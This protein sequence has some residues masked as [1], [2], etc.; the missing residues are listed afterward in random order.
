MGLED[1]ILSKATQ[2]QEE[3]T[4]HYLSM[5]ILASVKYACPGRKSQEAKGKL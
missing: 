1:C 4:M 2:A 3:T 5:S